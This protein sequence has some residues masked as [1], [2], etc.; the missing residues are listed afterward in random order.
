MTTTP[1]I[2]ESFRTDR[3]SILRLPTILL[4]PGLAMLAGCGGGDGSGGGGAASSSSSSSVTPTPAPAPTPSPTPSSTP[5][6]TPP[7]SAPIGSYD[8]AKLPDGRQRAFPTAEGYGA[9]SVGGR[10]GVVI[11]VTTLA[12]SG[13]G[14]LRDC[15]MATGARTCVFRV[16]GTIELLSQIKP[17]SGNLTIAGQTAPGGGIAI[18][19]APSNLTGSPIVLNVPDTIIRHIRIRPGPTSGAKQDTTDAITVDAKAKNTILDHV[20]LSWATDEPFN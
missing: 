10:G 9:A 7:S 18:R 6:P 19:N 12:D 11:P 20:T 4:M 5:T 14:S 3:Q 17:T 2:R 8:P 1:G 13:A 15:M 16:S